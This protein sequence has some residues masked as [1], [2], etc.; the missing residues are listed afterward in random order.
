MPASSPLRSRTCA[1]PGIRHASLYRGHQND[2]SIF[3]GAS[4]QMQL[5]RA[6][7]PRSLTRIL[8][9]LGTLI[10]IR[11]PAQAL[12]CGRMLRAKDHRPFQVFDACRDP[13]A[14]GGGVYSLQALLRLCVG[15]QAPQRDRPRCGC[16]RLGGGDRALYSP[17]GR[18]TGRLPIDQK[19][20]LAARRQHLKSQ[21][22]GGRAQVARDKNCLKKGGRPTCWWRRSGRMT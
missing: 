4:R 14:F 1:R 3:C 9:V 22:K 21:L 17:H 8:A 19:E 6:K 15:P 7:P 2:Y 5:N 12:S 18:R 20:K 16:V 13:T 11:S 10:G